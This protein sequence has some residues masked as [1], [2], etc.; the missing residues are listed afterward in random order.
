MNS[1]KS[2]INRFRDPVT[3]EYRAWLIAQFVFYSL[4]MVL[5][6]ISLFFTVPR[7]INV[8]S[9]A[10]QEGDGST[11]ATG[12]ITATVLI[13]LYFRLRNRSKN[14]SSKDFS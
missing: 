10:V 12:F 13:V 7:L 6:T 4:L 14:G 11:L 5:G 3:N 8:V 9:E 1:V 2:F